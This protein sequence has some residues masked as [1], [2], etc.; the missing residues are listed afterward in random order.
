MYD[1]HVQRSSLT[2]LSISGQ[3]YVESNRNTDVSED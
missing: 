2:A 3:G 1:R